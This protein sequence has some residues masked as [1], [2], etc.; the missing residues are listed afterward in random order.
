MNKLKLS[1]NGELAS[2]EEDT[3]ELKRAISI[4]KGEVHDIR[5]TLIG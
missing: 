5:N 4:I 1:S 2:V 3:Q